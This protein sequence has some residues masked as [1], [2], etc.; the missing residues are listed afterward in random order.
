M[1]TI[2]LVLLGAVLTL[3]G[4]LFGAF[5]TFKSTRAVPGERF[6]GGVPKGAIFNIEEPTEEFPEDKVLAKTE[7]FLSMLGGKG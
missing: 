4:V 7:K 2:G 1:E 5:I 3:F 6:L